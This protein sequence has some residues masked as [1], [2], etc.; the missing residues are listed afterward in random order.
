MTS[1]EMKAH[2]LFYMLYRLHFMAAV[3]EYGGVGTDGIADLYGITS[4]DLSHEIEVKVSKQDLAGEL[5]AI[6][7]HVKN[8]IPARSVHNTG[9][10]SDIFGSRPD[11]EKVV[12]PPPR[13]ARK[14]TKHWW[15]LCETAQSGD[16]RVK[17]NRFSFAVTPAL[18]DFALAE[19][20]E[21]PYGLIVVKEAYDVVT[22]KKADYLHKEKVSDK[23]L[24]KVLHKSCTEIQSVRQELVIAHANYKNLLKEK[25]AIHT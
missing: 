18:K 7:Y 8:R 12:E 21:T 4:A 22:V 9:M 10:M 23:V 14:G 25:S 13:G 24:R 5:Q 1:K 11:T 17:P 20:K 19:L 2:L 3:T 16:W 6:K 15:Y